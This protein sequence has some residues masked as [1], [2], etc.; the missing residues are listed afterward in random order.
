M[1]TTLPVT[2]VLS[3]LGFST[4]IGGAGGGA[5]RVELISAINALLQA[6]AFDVKTAV[7]DIVSP[8][9]AFRF[10]SVQFTEFPGENGKV[11]GATLVLETIGVE[12][13]TSPLAVP[14]TTIN[15]LCV[16]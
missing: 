9:S 8:P 5:V 6:M 11:Y 12:L 16:I 10:V 3:S 4:I 7:D 15:L 13:V 1:V 14:A 2:T